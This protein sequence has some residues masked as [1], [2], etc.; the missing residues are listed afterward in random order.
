M[1]KDGCDDIKYFF[2]VAG[3]FLRK[4]MKDVSKEERKAMIATHL[5]G[6]IEVLQ[7]F[8]RHQKTP[9]HLVTI[10]STSSWRMRDNETLYCALKAAKAAFTRNFARELARDFPGSKTTLVNPGG[11]K[12][13]NFWDA[14]GQ[15]ISAFMEPDKVA[16]I[17]WDEV[18]GQT[19]NYKELQI[20]RNNDG[21]PKIEYGPKIPELPF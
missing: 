18:A 19:T 2:C 8:H 15:D 10:A 11:L 6:P 17:I 14:S 9:Y 20:I 5:D 4:P 3:I 1:K 12:T 21:S 7:Q 13:P 16:K